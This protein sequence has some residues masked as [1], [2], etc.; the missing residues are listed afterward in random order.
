MPVPGKL[1]MPVPGNNE[2]LQCAMEHTFAMGL[3]SH[4]KHV[5]VLHCG[6]HILAHIKARSDGAAA[7]HRPGRKDA[8]KGKPE[9]SKAELL[10]ATK[11]RQEQLKALEGT[12]EGR[13]R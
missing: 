13:V 9:K 2:L 1:C 7:G 8:R 6:P 11:Q 10:E 12:R 4:H 3:C 5:G